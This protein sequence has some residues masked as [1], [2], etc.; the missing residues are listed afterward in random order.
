MVAAG[1]STSSDKQ[2]IF[3]LIPP[4]VHP[5]Y[6]ACFTIMSTREVIDFLDNVNGVP[7]FL[8]VTWGDEKAFVF[9]YMF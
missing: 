6:E 2:F 7:L 3:F 1:I 9:N 8:Y 4:Q 5:Y